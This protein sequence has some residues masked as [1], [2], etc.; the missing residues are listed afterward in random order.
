MCCSTFFNE[1]PR[2]CEGSEKEFAD[3]LGRGVTLI[4]PIIYAEVSIGFERVEELEP[5]LPE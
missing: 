2:W 5:A 3:A 1:D 4:N